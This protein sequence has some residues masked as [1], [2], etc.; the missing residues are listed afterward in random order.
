[1]KKTLI[2]LIIALAIIAGLTACSSNQSAVPDKQTV[3]CLVIGDRLN[4]RSTKLNNQ[5]IID[6]VSNT[7]RSGGALFVV[8]VDGNPEVV[9]G[10]S[11]ASLLEYADSNPT[12]FNQDV[13][14]LVSQTEKAIMSKS[15]ANDPEADMLK[16]L[17]MAIRVFS[18]YPD[19][20]KEI[21]TIDSGVSTEGLLNLS[22]N[23]FYA[24]PEALAE[25]LYTRNAIPDFSILSSITWYQLGDVEAP[26]TELSPNQKKK[27]GEIWTAVVSKGGGDL[28]IKDSLPGN[29]PHVASEYPS[30]SV[31]NLPKEDPIWYQ[32]SVSSPKKPE[33][34]N[35]PEDDPAPASIITKDDFSQPYILSEEVLGFHGDSD[36]YILSDEEVQEILK[37]IADCLIKSPDTTLL[38]IGTTAGDKATDY[39]YDLSNKRAAAVK[40]SL[41]ALGCDPDQ[42]IT[43]GMACT[44]PWHISGVGTSSPLASSNR[45]VVLLDINSPSAANII[46]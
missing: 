42:L 33:T 38:L 5:S 6:A 23:L 40:T 20:T 44:D 45:K 46:S 28:V 1:M 35:E 13:N 14:K 12:K 39:G 10:S 11:F 36:K 3:L 29:T 41:I 32:P 24:D 8:Q 34:I 7:I 9:Y 37:P 18:D 26:Q 2:T 43:I 30:V 4:S 19:A 27:L 15:K 22:R 25:E 17:T 31:V 16:A 21:I